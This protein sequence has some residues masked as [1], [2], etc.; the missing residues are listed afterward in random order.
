MLGACQSEHEA[1]QLQYQLMHIQQKRQQKLQLQSEAAREIAEEQVRTITLQLADFDE[2]WR[3]QEKKAAVAVA[4]CRKSVKMQQTLKNA[5]MEQEKLLLEEQAAAAN[6]HAQLTE[7]LKSDEDGKSYLCPGSLLHQFEGQLCWFSGGSCATDQ[8]VHSIILKLQQKLRVAE[9]SLLHRERDYKILSESY[10]SCLA[11]RDAEISVIAQDQEAIDAILA[12]WKEVLK[13]HQQFYNHLL[14]IESLLQSEREHR[15]QLEYENRRL[16][17]QFLNASDLQTRSWLLE[18][19]NDCIVAPQNSGIFDLVENSLNT[20]WQKLQKPERADC[21]ADSLSVEN[22]T[23]SSGKEHWNAIPWGENHLTLLT[24]DSNA[25]LPPLNA[26]PNPS[27]PLLCEQH[28][29]ALGISS[30]LREFDI[31]LHSRSLMPMHQKDG[32]TLTPPSRMTYTE[33]STDDIHHESWN[34]LFH[35]QAFQAQ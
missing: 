35:C 29:F 17:A 12:R 22:R 9:D 26:V 1:L 13:L 32:N 6:V 25:Y 10:H 24:T 18:P 14:D 23:Y 16:K 33:K 28:N 19:E 8:E 21:S 30:L 20:E 34:V 31:I 27:A 7:L 5:L 3:Q 11:E 4:E 15:R 2:Q